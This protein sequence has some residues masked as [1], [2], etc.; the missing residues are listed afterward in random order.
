VPKHIFKLGQERVLFLR[1][2]QK[3][4]AGKVESI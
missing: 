1:A 4:G 2:E 3:N